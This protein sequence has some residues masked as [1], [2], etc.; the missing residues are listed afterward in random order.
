MHNCKR[1]VVLRTTSFLLLVK[2]AVGQS[3]TVIWVLIWDGGLCRINLQNARGTPIAVMRNTFSQSVY[4]YNWKFVM[5][6]R[7]Y[8]K[9]LY[10]RFRSIM[11]VLRSEVLCSECTENLF[12]LTLCKVVF[13]RIGESGIFY[14]KWV[15]VGPLKLCTEDSTMPTDVHN[16]R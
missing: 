16:R 2:A 11:K 5:R 10:F 8:V 1:T 6:F 14:S 3:C 7:C 15:R 9:Q 13:Q 4:L 12:Y